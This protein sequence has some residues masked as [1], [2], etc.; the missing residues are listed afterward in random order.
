MKDEKEGRIPNELVA[1]WMA[2]S[3]LKEQVK[4]M[5]LVQQ[6]ALTWLIAQLHQQ[7]V[8]DA[9]HLHAHLIQAAKEPELGVLAPSLVQMLCGR[10]R[11]QIDDLTTAQEKSPPP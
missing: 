8:I 1:A 10:I 7:Q 2:V 3:E 5:H 9:Q 4:S 11:G 6:E